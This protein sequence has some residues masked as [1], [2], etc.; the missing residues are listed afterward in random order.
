MAYVCTPHSSSS[1]TGKL[2]MVSE[3]LGIFSPSVVEYMLQ[4]CPRA[5]RFGA[6]LEDRYLSGRRPA[7]DGR[8]RGALARLVTQ[9]LAA[10]DIRVFAYDQGKRRCVTFTRPK[11]STR[12][13]SPFACDN[14]IAGSEC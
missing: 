7:S 13:C 10:N 8:R 12:S 6:D 3:I 9:K 14:F 1:F 2:L 4:L 11:S 5:K